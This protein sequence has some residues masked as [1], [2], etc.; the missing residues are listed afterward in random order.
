VLAVDGT[1]D[2][3]LP[4]QAEADLG[5]R[6]GRIMGAS[7]AENALALEAVRDDIRL[8]GHIGLPTENRPNARYQH[9]FVNRRPVQDRLLKGALRAAYGDL[10]FAGRQPMAALFLELD[11]E[12]VDVNVHPAKAEVRFR[13][14]GI[15][16]GLMIGAIKE[17]LG[18]AGCRTTSTLGGATLGA[19]AGSGA[20][21]AGRGSYPGRGAAPVA[22]GLA[23]Q[24]SRFQAPHAPDPGP[25]P[26]LDVGAPASRGEDDPPATEEPGENYPLGAARAQLHDSYILAQTAEGML[27][28]DQHAAHE[29]LVYERLKA[30]LE[31]QGIPRQGL[32]LPEV[33]ELEDDLIEHLTARRDE[34]EGLGLVLE[35]FGQGAVVVREL[36]AMLGS[37]DVRRLVRDLAEDLAEIDRAASLVTA[38]ER[39]AA[40]IA[41]H[42]SVRAG[43][44]LNLAEMNAL[45]R[46]MEATPGSGQCNHG[47][48]TY[49]ALSLA[50]IERL[51]KR[52]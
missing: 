48:P 41:C 29:R 14:P 1:G 8:F 15:V 2:A 40:T 24:A 47:R 11:P 46:Q 45:L 28:V 16:R 49:V 6:L 50:E 39:I 51:F 32:L 13:E 7:F 52:R 23:E 10:L 21:A 34:L 31:A 44:R 33:V 19:F 36:P 26:G 9:L 3:L 43:R 20:G 35:P 38:L 25:Q 42:G 27:L 37:P 30:G 22:P 17:R 12:R 4:D 18:A 5:R